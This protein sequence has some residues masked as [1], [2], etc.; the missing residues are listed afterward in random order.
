MFSNLQENRRRFP[1]FFIMG[2]K[3]HRD[4]FNFSV[5]NEI[6]NIIKIS[7]I[8]N[9]QYKIPLYIQQNTRICIHGQ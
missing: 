6:Q 5:K 8:Y 3:N 7:S 4:Q 1:P 2:S 9:L